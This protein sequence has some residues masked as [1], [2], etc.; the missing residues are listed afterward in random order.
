MAKWKTAI[1][2]V[3]AVGMTLSVTGNVLASAQSANTAINLTLPD[4]NAESFMANFNPY[5]PNTRYGS[6]YMFEPLII[7][8]ALN[9]NETPWLATAYSWNK[10]GDAVTFTI[11]SGVKWS[12]GKPFTAE[13]VVFTYNLLKN[14]PALDANG[15]WTVLKDVHRTGDNTVVMTLKH[16]DSLIWSALVQIAIVPEHIW[17]KVKDPATFTNPHPV[18][19]GPY[20]VRSLNSAQYVLAKNPL[21]WQA[22]KISVDSLTFDGGAI[23]SNQ[24]GL[25]ALLNGQLD[26]G[27]YFLPNIQQVYVKR[28][29]S[30]N[31]YWFPPS[32]PQALYLNLTEYPFNLVP[33]RQALDYAIDKQAINVKGESGYEPVASATGILLPYDAKDLDKAVAAKY[34]YAYNPSKAMAI[35]KSAGFKLNAKGQLLSP[36]GTPVSIKIEVQN[37]WS[38]AIEDCQIISSDLKPLGID[39]HIYTP[40]S[41]TYT[42]DMITGNYQAAIQF[43]LV[44]ADPGLLFYYTFDSALSAPIGKSASSNYERWENK[45]TDS[46]IN[47]YAQTNNLATKLKILHKLEAQVAENLPVIPL[48]YSPS[49]EE[50]KTNKVVGW[51]DDSNPYAISSPWA[52]PDVILVLTRLRPAH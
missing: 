27:G 38:D 20:T 5:S 2:T 50:Y 4:Y 28:D 10:N 26:W 35:L 23:E 30:A 40:S 16:P 46:L 12:D 13:D 37:G 19:T 17:A 47:A 44:G 51:P 33:F 3:A 39:V 1:A 42:N 31:K 49:W 18:V 24:G 14:Y 36:K 25:L 45:T 9:G 32:G 41:T 29:P 6:Y 52:F 8:N 21:Y 22:N 48:N 7:I 43:P 11:R 15:L 34:Q